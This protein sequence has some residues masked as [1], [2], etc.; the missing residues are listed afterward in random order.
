MEDFAGCLS[1]CGLKDLGY[2]GYDFTWNNRREGADNI[3]CRL[4][5][6]TATASFLD[7][8]LFM[9][10]EHI[11]IEES[12]HLAILI[13]V[14]DEVPVGQHAGPR[15]FM[16]EEMWTKHD[17]YEEMFKQVWNQRGG[18]VQGLDDLW[19]Q[20]REVSGDIKQWSYET[21]GSVRAEIKLLRAKLEAARTDAMTNGTSLEVREL[22]SKLHAVYEKEEIMYRQR[23]RQDWLK[24]GDKNTKYFQ[25]WATHRRRKNMI[26]GLRRVDG[27]WCDT[28]DGMQSLASSFF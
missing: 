21:F 24:G 1:E 2:R 25:N 9:S 19:R 16:F 10:V 15:S 13:K 18:S 20:L 12:D 5:R 6:G 17:G 28:T 7:L 27:S 4:D 11:T 14:R 8:F 22:E 3:Q 26:K 23:S